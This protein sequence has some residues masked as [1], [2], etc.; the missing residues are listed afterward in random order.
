M[1]RLRIPYIIDS[2]S[3]AID[4]WAQSEVALATKENLVVYRTD[5]TFSGDKNMTRSADD[6]PGCQISDGFLH[7][8]TLTG[9]I[10]EIFLVGFHGISTRGVNLSVHSSSLL[11]QL[12]SLM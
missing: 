5:G 8:G 7:L 12:R 6:P 9:N 2:Y 4:S 11:L 10:R 3:D 1:H